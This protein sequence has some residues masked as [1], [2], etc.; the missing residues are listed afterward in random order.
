LLAEKK[1]K[2]ALAIMELNFDSNHPDS[3]WSYHMLAQAH[4]A[5]GL[6]EKAIADYRKVLELH[7]DDDWAKEQIQTLSNLK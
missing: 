1:N 5:N 7:P 4:E 3:L 2:E 6:T